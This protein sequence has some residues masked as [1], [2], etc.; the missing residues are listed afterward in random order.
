MP[1]R[2]RN[3]LFYM[4][5]VYEDATPFQLAQVEVSK[6]NAIAHNDSVRRQTEK[7]TVVLDRSNISP[8]INGL[9][10]QTLRTMRLYGYRSVEVTSSEKTKLLVE[11]H[12]A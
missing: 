4:K 1:A 6:Q 9:T 11:K 8:R 2:L 5:N 7:R 12:H 10:R 3:P